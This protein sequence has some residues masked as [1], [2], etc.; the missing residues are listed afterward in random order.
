MNES[1]WYRNACR[2]ID[3]ALR[4]A[5]AK[6]LDRRATVALV[7]AAYPFGPRT[8]WPYKQWLKARRETLQRLLPPR[9]RP[10]EAEPLPLFDD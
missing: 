4:E 3:A 8:C 10:A 9:P 6:G 1:H 2:A 7:D 5:E